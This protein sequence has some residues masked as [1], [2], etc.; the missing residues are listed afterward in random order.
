MVVWQYAK[1]HG[2]VIVSKDKDFDDLAKSKGTP[3]QVI[4]VRL[5]NCRRADLIAAFDRR[6]ENMRDM[7]AAGVAVVEL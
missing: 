5:G 3:P 1:A 4:W 7:L 6:W 2:M